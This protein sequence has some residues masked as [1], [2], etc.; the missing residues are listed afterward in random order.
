MAD[1][2]N[3]PRNLVPSHQVTVPAAAGGS[4]G[5][6]GALVAVKFLGIVDPVQI[7]AVG[8]LVGQLIS[9]GV[10]YLQNGGRHGEV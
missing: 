2:T 1:D 7:A 10:S 3:P 9:A 4:M 8:T 6:I 5:I